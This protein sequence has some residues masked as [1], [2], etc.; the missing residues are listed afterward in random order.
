M[1]KLVA[2]DL[3]P[4]TRYELEP[5][6][7]PDAHGLTAP[8]IRLCSGKS[9]GTLPKNTR[10]VGPSCHRRHLPPPREKQH[11]GWQMRPSIIYG[12]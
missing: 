5:S 4:R 12:R 8:R 11:L 6:A 9:R 1:R 2:E 3:D 10:Y 7:I